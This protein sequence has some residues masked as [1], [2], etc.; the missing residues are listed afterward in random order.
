M[1]HVVQVEASLTGWFHVQGCPSECVCVIECYQ[2]HHNTLHLQRVGRRDQTKKG[3]K[4]ERIKE[5][6]ER[7]NEKK[8]RKKERKLERKKERKERK[9]KNYRRGAP[10]GCHWYVSNFQW[11]FTRRHSITSQKTWIMGKKLAWE[12]WTVN[13]SEKNRRMGNADKGVTV[14]RW[15]LVVYYT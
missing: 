15:T 13:P 11:L 3:R 4:K 5:R 7:K 8:E 12:T 10:V 9:K 14:H 1:L 2:M 6:E